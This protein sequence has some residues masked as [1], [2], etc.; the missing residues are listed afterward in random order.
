M[1]GLCIHGVYS[2]IEH[3]EV[4]HEYDTDLLSNALGAVS[5]VYAFLRLLHNGFD[6]KM[7]NTEMLSNS[8][9]IILFHV[10]ISIAHFSVAGGN[11]LDNTKKIDVDVIIHMAISLIANFV[12]AIFGYYGRRFKKSKSPENSFY[13]TNGNHN[14]NHETEIPT[15]NSI[16]KA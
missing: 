14:N 13:S 8:F 9:G 16:H 15:F 12:E 3:Q 2:A 1:I 11:K 4:A 10:I 5:M 7:I 6:M